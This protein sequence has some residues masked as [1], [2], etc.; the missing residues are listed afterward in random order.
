MSELPTSSLQKLCRCF[1]LSELQLPLQ[2][3]CR[4]A[5]RTPR[6]PRVLLCSGTFFSR[7]LVEVFPSVGSVFPPPVPDG[8]VFTGSCSLGLE[9]FSPSCLQ[10]TDRLLPLM[11][12]PS[13]CDHVTRLV[14]RISL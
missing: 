2:S 3:S 6:D 4:A 1:S 8:G 11:V 13:G 5:A 9:D 10:I 12:S 7:A 14:M